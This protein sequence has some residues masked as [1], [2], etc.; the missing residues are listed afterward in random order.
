MVISS[1][2]SVLGDRTFGH[3]KVN[4]HALKDLHFDTECRGPRLD[5]C[6]RGLRRLLHDIA[7]LAGHLQ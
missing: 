3:M 7:K 1:R 4:I 5:V 2:W 6:E